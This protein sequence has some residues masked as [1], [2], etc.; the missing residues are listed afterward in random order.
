MG[1]ISTCPLCKASITGI[2]KVEHAATTDQKVYS[3]TIPCDY[4]SS[5]VF[6]P[7]DQEFRDNGLEV[8]LFTF[9]IRIIQFTWNDHR[10]FCK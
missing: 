3:Q 9:I 2:K 6:I 10:T 1:K 5:D 7:V 8:C 4:T